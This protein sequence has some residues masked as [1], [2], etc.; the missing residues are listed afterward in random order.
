[1]HVMADAAAGDTTWPSPTI[2]IEWAGQELVLCPQRA[3][4]WPARRTLLVA[5]L[6]LGKS[7]AFRAAGL[8]VPS[9]TT[10]SDLDRLAALVA[11]RDAQRLVLLGDFVHGRSSWSDGLEERWRAFRRECDVPITLVRGNH[12]R[13]AGDPADAWAVA[14]V[15]HLDD[16]PFSLRH[17][18]EPVP[19]RHVLAGHDHPCLRLRDFGRA[20][21]RLPCFHFGPTVAVLPAFGSFTGMHP[22][23]RQ[24]GDRVFV[25]TDDAVIE[26]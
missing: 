23:R 19:A 16:G 3:V 13:R 12:D 4:W 24:P 20:R 2:E 6:H 18:P 5:D 11:A 8:P 9:G 26:A 21:L 17:H 10:R 1:M 15:D 25:A 7:D 14:A 22:V